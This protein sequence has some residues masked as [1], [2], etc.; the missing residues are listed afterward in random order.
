MPK[1]TE[2]GA[3][4]ILRTSATL[5]PAQPVRVRIGRRERTRLGVE[6]GQFVTLK[7]GRQALTAVVGK[8]H[9]GDHAGDGRVEILF[10]RVGGAVPDAWVIAEALCGRR[11][12]VEAVAAPVVTAGAVDMA[13]A[14]A[15]N[16][17]P[18]PVDPV[19]AAVNEGRG[20]S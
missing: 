2:I 16:A 5:T 6:V 18:A 20:R 19:E 11:V 4:V 1:T 9:R 3:R 7:F 13:A 15:V 8:R 17:A 14:A 12:R 10:G